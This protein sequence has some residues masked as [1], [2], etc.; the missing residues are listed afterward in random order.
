M[1]EQLTAT[2]RAWLVGV[3]FFMELT[4]SALAMLA[5]RGLSAVTAPEK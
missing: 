1:T 4:E 2:A 3:P 5:Q